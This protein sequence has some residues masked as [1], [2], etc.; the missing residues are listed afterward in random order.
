MPNSSSTFCNPPPALALKETHLRREQQIRVNG[1]D[2]IVKLQLPTNLG[3]CQ[4]LKPNL[5]FVCHDCTAALLCSGDFWTAMNKVSLME[6]EVWYLIPKSYSWLWSF[7]RCVMCRSE[8][9]QLYA[10]KPIFDAMGI[11]L[12]VCLNEHIDAEVWFLDFPSSS[13]LCIHSVIHSFIH[14][15][16][17]SGTWW[18]CK[19]IN[20]Y[21]YCSL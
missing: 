5:G 19:D 11:Q 14:L 8:A 6:T 1:K 16:F 4:K 10:R 12:V 7:C 2:G 15:S 20:E 18:A 3:F 9:H 13:S 21:F 17:E